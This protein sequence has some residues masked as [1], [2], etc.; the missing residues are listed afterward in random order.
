M[1]K[2]YWGVIIGFATLLGIAASVWGVSSYWHG[3]CSVETIKEAKQDDLIML[4][5]NQSKLALAQ[6]RL[7]WLE[8]RLYEME[9]KYGCPHCSGPT[10]RRYDKYLREHQALEQKVQQ[11]MGN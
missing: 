7:R 8:E 9:S 5:V 1:S 6:Q 4:A 10:K 11:L 2:K 3:Y